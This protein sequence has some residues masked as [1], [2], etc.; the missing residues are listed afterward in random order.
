[1]TGSPSHCYKLSKKS[2]VVALAEVMFIDRHQV[3]VII[4][5]CTGLLKRAVY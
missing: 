3:P 4:L 2:Y 1:M 5:I